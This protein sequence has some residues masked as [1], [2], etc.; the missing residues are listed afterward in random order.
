MARAR[1]PSPRKVIGT[2]PITVGS[3]LLVGLVLLG[4]MLL[5][6]VVTG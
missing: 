1:P 5:S 3:Y 6:G 2:M 4:E